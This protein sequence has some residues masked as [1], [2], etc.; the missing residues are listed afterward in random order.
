MSIEGK[1]FWMLIYGSL[2][3]EAIRVGADPRFIL[4]GHRIL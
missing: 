2:T 4:A 3:D 1:N